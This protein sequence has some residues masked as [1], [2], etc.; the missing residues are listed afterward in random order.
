MIKLIIDAGHGWFT[1][2]KESLFHRITFG[3]FKGKPIIRE[4]NV[5]EAV[6]NKISVLY[7][8]SVFISNEWQDI[9]LTERV[10]REHKEATF[11]SLFLSIHADAYTKKDKA[12]GGRIYYYGEEGK[13][14]A[15]YLTKGLKE[16][17]YPIKL[18][19]PKRANFYVLKHTQSRAILFELA[20]MTTKD[21]VDIL[22]MEEFRN[23]VAKDL[24]TL[25]KQI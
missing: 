12:H 6:A 17:G 14:L 21:E 11:D 10:R 19:E 25:I 7:E 24:V 20:F 5:N 15:Y 3:I 23:K 2:G 13:K 18:R 1:K 16:M 22:M 4:N 8:D 9:S